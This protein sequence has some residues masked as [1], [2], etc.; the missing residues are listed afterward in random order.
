MESIDDQSTSQTVPQWA[1]W[2]LILLIPVVAL[3]VAGTQLYLSTHHD[4][5]TWKGGGMGMFAGADGA[6]NRYAK[7]FMADGRGKRQPLTQL[8]PE[9]TKLINRALNFPTR[10]N[11]RLAA[12]AIA[13]TDWVAARERIPVASVDAFGKNAG[14]TSD[15]YYMMVPFGPR[16]PDEKWK[17]DVQIEY[18]KM[19]YDPQ[20]RHAHT[21]LA[22]TF[23]FHPDE[24]LPHG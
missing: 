19:S 20:T 8:P 17:W 1:V 3:V 11:F 7:T 18:W 13:T 12:R 5:T 2:P 4:L 24:L 10:Q 23:V 14:T 21:V 9:Q 15:S 16:P 6:L 22:E